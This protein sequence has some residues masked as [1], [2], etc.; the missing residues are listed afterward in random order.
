MLIQINDSINDLDVGT[1]CSLSKFT[2]NKYL[3]G[4]ADI[5]AGCAAIQRSLN[6]LEI[7]TE[8]NLMKFSQRK[9]NPVTGDI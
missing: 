4:V 8:R 9:C 7:W 3:G 5:P 6:R 2:D 1:K